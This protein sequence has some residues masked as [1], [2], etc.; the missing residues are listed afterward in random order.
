MR[1]VLAP[2]R[3]SA[4]ASTMPPRRIADSPAFAEYRHTLAAWL[5]GESDDEFAVHRAGDALCQEVRA[6][7]VPVEHLLYSVQSAVMQPSAE[8]IRSARRESAYAAAVR[9]L[10]QACYGR[11][12]ELRVTHTTDGRDWTLM[13][14]P[15]R[16]RTEHGA[17]GR[18]KDWLACVSAGDRRYITPVPPRWEQWGESELAAAITKARPDMRGSA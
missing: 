17:A 8:S 2:M 9:E 12:P 1:G 6:T 16:T 14:I 15:E 4:H 3:S 10:M 18:R 11:E 13:L 5:G 7:G